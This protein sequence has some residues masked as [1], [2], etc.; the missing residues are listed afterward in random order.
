[1]ENLNFIA[2]ECRQQIMD[3]HL[4][5]LNLNLQSL[6]SSL[7]RPFGIANTN[8]SL[9]TTTITAKIIANCLAE[10]NWRPIQ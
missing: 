8:N 10:L 1:M 2:S 7:A 4:S 6:N 3:F 5:Q 9:R